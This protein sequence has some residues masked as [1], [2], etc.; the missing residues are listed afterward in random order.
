MARMK[1]PDG[2]TNTVYLGR[3][4]YGDDVYECYGCDRTRSRGGEGAKFIVP[5]RKPRRR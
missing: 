1:C 5:R 2:H 4:Q 3:D